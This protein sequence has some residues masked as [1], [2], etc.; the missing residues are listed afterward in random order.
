[1]KL[2]LEYLYQTKAMVDITD[3]DPTHFKI[4]SRTVLKMIQQNQSGW[5]EM[6]PPVV[7][8]EVITKGLFGHKR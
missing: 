4:W 2:L 3:Y 1:M 8:K 7:A 5:E 6:V